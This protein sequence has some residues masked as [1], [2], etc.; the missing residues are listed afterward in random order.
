MRPADASPT[1]ASPTRIVLRP[2]TRADE[3][4]LWRMLRLAVHLP[5]NAPPLPPDLTSQPELARYVA[6]WMRRDGDL[7]L[8]AESDGRPVGAAWLRRWLGGDRGYGFIDA[9]TPE[10][11]IAVAPEQRGRGIGTS[12]LQSLIA[13]ARDDAAAISLS[14]ARDN[15]ARRLYQRLGFEILGDPEAA[16]W[17]MRRSL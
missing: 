1:G 9:A 6:G 17:T 15:P 11:T 2:L 16:S 7:G 5:P 12:L 8:A 13:T 10:L 4:L 3:P 14:V